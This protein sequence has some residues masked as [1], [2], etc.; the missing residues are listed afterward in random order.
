MNLSIGN[1]ISTNY[2]PSL[3]SSNVVSASP[4]ADGDHDGSRVKGTG[5]KGGH[6]LSALNQALTQS[7]LTSS[8]SATA[9]GGSQQQALAAFS[10]SLYGALHAQISSQSVGSGVESSGGGSGLSNGLQSLIQQLS[11]AGPAGAVSD[12]TIA[13]LQSS[14]NNLLAANGGNP[15]TSLGGFLKTLSC[16]LQSSNTGGAIASSTV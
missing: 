15:N 10:Q 13:A 12:P 11:S 4:D 16:D 14:F 9:S 5:Q 1:S 6:L 8:Q 7:G 2:Q 3:N